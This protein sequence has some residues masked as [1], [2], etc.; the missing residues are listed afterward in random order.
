MRHQEDGNPSSFYYPRSEAADILTDPNVKEAVFKYPLDQFSLNGTAYNEDYTSINDVWNITI[1]D[2]S[3][4]FAEDLPNTIIR[5]VTGNPSSAFISWKTFLPSDAYVMPRNRGPI[6]NLAS[7]EN[8]RLLVHCQDSLYITRDR[9]TLSGGQTNISLGAADLFDLQPTEVVTS[10]NGYGGISHRTYAE[11]TKIGYVF[12]DDKQGK[13]FR[14]LGKLEE[15][16]E[17]NMSNFFR[18][19]ITKLPAE[20]FKRFDPT[21]YTIDYDEY[22]DTLYV[23]KIDGENSFCISFSSD[24][25]SFASYHDWLPQWMMSTRANVNFSYKNVDKGDITSAIYK[26]R[27]NLP[28]RYYAYDESGTVA[29]F[30]VDMVFNHDNKLSKVFQTL[31]WN[32]QVTQDDLEIYNETFD[33]IAVYSFNKVSGWVTVIP[34][35]GMVGNHNAARTETIWNF[36][37]FRNIATGAKFLGGLST[38]FEFLSSGINEQLPWFQRSRFIDKHIVV[39]FRYNNVTGKDF[40][41][42]GADAISRQSFR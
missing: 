40:S 24:Y 42:F 18:D 27:T 21:G 25:N 33:Q 30:Q 22:Y 3:S 7:V 5:S 35:V 39:R 11:V 28:G 29:P 12:I 4:K 16:D 34:K 14:Y 13:M 38:N 1:F 23:A 2:P 15:L 6:W 37:G 19:N 9:S 10:K 36:N 31:R 26:H 41:F 17:Q 8:E 20:Q 32:T